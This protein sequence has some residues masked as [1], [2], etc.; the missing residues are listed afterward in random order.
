VNQ[1]VIDLD[2]I[3]RAMLRDLSLEGDLSAGELGR[4]FGL[5]QPAAWRRVKRMQEAGILKGVRMEVDRAALGFG[6]TVFLGVKLATK[7]RVSLEDFERAVTAIPE[8]Q[9]V[10]HVLGLFDYRLRVVARDI[11]DFE[12]VLRRRIMTLPGL[13]QVE[14]NVLLTEERRPGPLG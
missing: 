9:V 5:S 4:R 3:D 8:V 10:Q 12:R 2:D 6:V 7:G 11:A 13:G 14:A 1:G